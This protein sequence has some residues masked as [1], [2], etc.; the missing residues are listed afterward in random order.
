MPEVHHQGI[1]TTE[2][3][4]LKLLNTEHRELVRWL[5]D[6]LAQNLVAIKSFAT[7]IIDQNKDQADDTAEIADI[8]KQA[9]N[10]AYRAVYD[11]MQELRAQE[12]ADEVTSIA[13]SACLKE[14]RLS[15]KHI[16]YQLNID[17]ELEDLDNFTKS[18][19]LR[20]LRTFINYSKLSKKPPRLIIDLK[21]ASHNARHKIEMR[22]NHQGG[23]EIAADEAP[24]ISALCERIK[25]IGGEAL[26]EINGSDSIQ[27]K[28][29]FDPLNLDCEAPE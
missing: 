15:E 26:I 23:F 24:G 5:H 21:A 14:A 7:A 1:C 2:K 19:I 6:D 9:A 28:L 3:S 20:S 11:L 10:D 29:S 22:L 4:V 8:I 16:E 17:P 18:V 25:A 27:L 12:G 13:I